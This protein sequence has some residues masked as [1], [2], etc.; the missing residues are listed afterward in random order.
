MITHFKKNKSK[1]LQSVK[2]KKQRFVS[3]GDGSDRKLLKYAPL[4]FFLG[5]NGGGSQFGLGVDQRMS[6][7]KVVISPELSEL[8]RECA[9]GDNRLCFAKNLQAGAVCLRECYDEIC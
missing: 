9:G 2:V 4:L 8:V 3:R 5:L 1:K 7:E 6:S